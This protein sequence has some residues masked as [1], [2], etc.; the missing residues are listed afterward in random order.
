MCGRL[1][2]GG[3]TM[4]SAPSARGSSADARLLDPRIIFRPCVDVRRRSCSLSGDALTPREACFSAS[5]L[6]SRLSSALARLFSLFC[7]NHASLLRRFFAGS[8]A[9][10]FGG[11]ARG[12]PREPNT[13]PTGPNDQTTPVRPVHVRASWQRMGVAKNE[14][15]KEWEWQRMRVAKNESGK[16]WEW[17]RMGVAKNESGKE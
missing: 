11:I 13:P 15:G 16:E 5:N 4:A 7:S 9:T 6:A 3:Q 1:T 8:F 10:I 2:N 17:Q 12:W 14:S